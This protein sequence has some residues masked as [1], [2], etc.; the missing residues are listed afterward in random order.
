MR[1]QNKPYAATNPTNS[2]TWG[3]IAVQIFPPTK[4]AKFAF[5]LG[6]VGVDDE[7]RV[8]PV[9]ENAE[10]VEDDAYLFTVA[11]NFLAMVRY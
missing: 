2:L 10:D 6:G 1:Y 4:G 9:P 5:S 7:P 3:S 8:W 11:V